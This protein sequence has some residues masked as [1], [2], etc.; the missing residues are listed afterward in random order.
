MFLARFSSPLGIQSLKPWYLITGFNFKK[1][2]LSFIKDMVI[3]NEFEALSPSS[4]WDFQITSYGN[5]GWNLG[6]GSPASVAAQGGAWDLQGKEAIGSAVQWWDILETMCESVLLGS[7]PNSTPAS[8]G[9]STTP[10]LPVLNISIPST[11]T[12]PYWVW[13]QVR[14]MN[15]TQLLSHGAFSSWII[16]GDSRRAGLEKRFDARAIKTDAT[17][18][19]RQKTRSLRLDLNELDAACNECL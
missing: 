14:D 13:Q 1:L 7:G 17:F 6:G 15:S 12:T 11:R 4:G 3:R 16:L 19:L 18:E 2:K 10:C 5:A 9:T 8:Q